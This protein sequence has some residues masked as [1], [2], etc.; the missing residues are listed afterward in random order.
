MDSST[1]DGDEISDPNVTGAYILRFDLF[2][3]PD[4]PQSR[5]H[6]QHPWSLRQPS[7]RVACLEWVASML[8][9][10]H[11]WAFYCRNQKS[12]WALTWCWLALLLW[13]VCRTGCGFHLLWEYKYCKNSRLPG[14][15]VTPFSVCGYESSKK[16]V[17][18]RLLVRFSPMKAF[19]QGL[20]PLWFHSIVSLNTVWRMHLETSLM[21]LMRSV[22]LLAAIPRLSMFW[23]YW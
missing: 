3:S 4:H 23:G 6:R 12:L 9:Q 5:G 13:A 2:S 8:T 11:Q 19:C 15:V 20:Q 21:F 17:F 22:A 18:F 14:S 7:T 16:T 1:G 10:K